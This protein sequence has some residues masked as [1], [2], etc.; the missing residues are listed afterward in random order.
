MKN[1]QFILCCSAIF[2]L[3]A[4]KGQ[5]KEIT[6]AFTQSYTL[7]FNQDYAGAITELKNVYEADSYEINLRLG[8]LYYLAQKYTESIVY[9][10]KAVQIMPA[11]T[12]P[13]I[14]L[15]AVYSLLENWT[16]VEISYRS[17]LKL[18]SKNELIN[19]KLGL[20]YFYRKDY[21]LAK[22]YFDVSLNLTP[23][24]YNNMLMSGWV[25]YYLGK[26]NDA[27]ILFNKVLLYSPNDVSALEGLSLI[28]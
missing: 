19:Y 26:K 8:W 21:E 24:G 20:I 28:K 16:A 25:N 11:A 6:V 12:E 15:V 18:D 2:I 23:F 17:I 1:I 7:E 22:K 9:Y 27:T 10:E 5:T 14:G 4:A 3:T 13:I